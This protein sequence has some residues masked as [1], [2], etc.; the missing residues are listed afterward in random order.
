MKHLF[1]ASTTFNI[2]VAASIAHALK[3][4]D[5]TNETRLV[6]I[7]Q[8]KIPDTKAI[9]AAGYFDH[10]DILPLS[11]G[12]KKQQRQQ[13]F[14][15][16]GEIVSRFPARHVY[17]GNDRRIEFQYCYHLLSQQQTVE[18]HYYDDG[19]YSYTGYNKNEYIDRL[20]YLAKRITTGQWIQRPPTPGGG[21]YISQV[22]LLFPQHALEQ[23]RE[24]HIEPVNKNSFMAILPWFDNSHA[25]PP[26]QGYD[27]LALMPHSS[28]TSSEFIRHIQKLLAQPAIKILVKP[29]PRD[30]AGFWQQRLHGNVSYFTDTI[31]FETFILQ[32]D[33]DTVILSGASSALMTAIWL[34][35][36]LQII[37]G[38]LYDN[39]NLTHRLFKKLG[40]GF[41]TAS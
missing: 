1:L 21:K 36:S 16:L 26:V 17:T 10:T 29:H 19:L 4:T 22:H 24:K 39:H 13:A 5:S 31:S 27:Y 40:I 8:K 18:G 33:D 23:L 11:T 34:K 6:L 41:L 9:N 32:L 38:E 12:N 2:L 20:E 15:Q 3:K 37:C 30:D 28:V 35:P 7:D 14:A 25:H